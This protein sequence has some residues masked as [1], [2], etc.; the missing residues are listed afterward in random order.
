[1][2]EYIDLN[3]EL[4]PKYPIS[5]DFNPRERTIDIHLKVDELESQEDVVDFI[6]D[7][8]DRFF[9]MTWE[10]YL[11]YKGDFSSMEVRCAGSDSATK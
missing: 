11:R 1:V 8:L 10:D 4:E 6:K 3:Y 5:A 7:V 2:S 9:K